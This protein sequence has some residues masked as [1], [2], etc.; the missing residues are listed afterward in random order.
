MSTRGYLVLVD[1]KKNIRDAAYISSD[2]YPSYTGLEVLDAISDHNIPE[3][4]EKM[5]KERPDDLEMVEGIQR[6]WYVKDKTNKD[7]YFVDYVYEVNNTSMELDM[8]HF[9]NKALTIREEEISLYRYIFEN[10][11][12]LY[13][14]LALNEK[15]MMLSNDFYKEIRDMVKDGAWIKDF[16]EIVDK[17]ASVLYLDHGRIKESWNRDNDSFLKRVYDSKGGSLT[18]HIDNFANKRNYFPY[19]QTPFARCPLPGKNYSSATGAEKGIA[20]LLRNRPEDVRATMQIYEE[21]KQYIDSISALYKDTTRPLA[22]R[23]EE[24]LCL[25]QNMMERMQEVKKEHSILGNS[26]DFLVRQIRETDF[27]H[28]RHAKE[29]EEKEQSKAPSIS[30]ILEDAAQRAAENKSHHREETPER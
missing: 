8:F 3:L 5:K 14:P 16:Q 10:E 26:G 28:Y 19:I 9:G 17:N 15:T 2:G 4:I 7:G 25:R 12:S 30:E 6:D 20:E 1:D 29:L 11:E 22:E 27:I 23:S 18:F 13:Y 24:A 21:I